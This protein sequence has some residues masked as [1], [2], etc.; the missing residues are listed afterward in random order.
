MSCTTETGPHGPEQ[1]LTTDNSGREC[2]GTCV[3]GRCQGHRD[4]H[5][6]GMTCTRRFKAR[7]IQGNSSFGSHHISA[8]ATSLSPLKT[9]LTLAEMESIWSQKRRFQGHRCPRP[10][11]KLMRP[12]VTKGLRHC[13]MQIL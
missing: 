8:P 5:M 4:G 10:E 2:L 7:K 13:Q 3:L 9:G 11:G 1:Y 12:R 6:P